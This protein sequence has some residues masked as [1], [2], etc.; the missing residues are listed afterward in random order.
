LTSCCAGD[1]L[2]IERAD[3][4]SMIRKVLE[5]ILWSYETLTYKIETVANLITLLFKVIPR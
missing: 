5:T 1:I 3:S 2:P 4:S